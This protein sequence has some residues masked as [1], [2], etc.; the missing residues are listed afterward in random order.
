MI[1]KTILAAGVAVMA[2]GTVAYA[3]PG[4]MKADAPKTLAEATTQANTMFDRMDANNDGKIDAADRA[5]RQA[6]MFDR[7]D[8]DKNGSI[9]KAEF[10]AMHEMRGERRGKGG[11]GDHMGMRGGMMGDTNGDGTITRAEFDAGVKAR[12]AKLDTNGDGTVSATER[13]AARDKMRAERKEMRD[14]RQ[15]N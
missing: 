14:A 11:R 9:S 4:M 5:A 3:A 7:I 8:T 15:A 13:T 1:K 2:M 6:R 10:A 12:F